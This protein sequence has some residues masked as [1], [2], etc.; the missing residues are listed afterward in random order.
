M[1]P[2]TKDDLRQLRMQLLND[3]ENVI[4][5]KM[6]STPDREGLEWL[7]SKAVRQMMNISPATLQSIRISGKIRFR[8][9]LGSYYYNRTDILNLFE[10]GSR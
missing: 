6:I 10:N 2:I 4:N 5:E 7:R 8:K 1:E 9:I 3:I